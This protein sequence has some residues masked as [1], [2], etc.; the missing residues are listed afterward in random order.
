MGAPRRALT[1][2]RVLGL[3]PGVIILAVLLF[4]SLVGCYVG[5]SAGK[6]AIGLLVTF[7]CGLLSLILLV[8]PRGRITDDSMSA[9]LGGHDDSITERFLMYLA[10][11]LGV[12]MAAGG[13]VVLHLSKARYARPIDYERDVLKR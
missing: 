6:P 13:F 11:V 9:E 1:S 3:G 5:R 2:E 4:L 10:M 12:L 7:A 8:S